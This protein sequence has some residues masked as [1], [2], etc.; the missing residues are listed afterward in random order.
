MP[1]TFTYTPAAGTVLQAGIPEAHGHLHTVRHHRLFRSYHDRRAYGPPGQSGD[2]L[3]PAVRHSAGNA[4]SA[5]QL[6]ATAN[7]PGT[8]SYSPAAGAVLPTGTQQ[9]TV[10]FTP[11]NT[12]DY[13][14]ATAHDSLT[15]TAPP[16]SAPII[17]WNTP[18]PIQYGT[19]LSSVQLNAVA[20]VPG[21]FTYTPAAGTVL[22]AGSQ[23]IT[24]VFTSSDTT[25]HSTAT[26][27]VQELTVTQASPV[28]AWAPLSPIQQGTALSAAQLDATANVP[29]T[30]SYS[31][32]LGAVLPGVRQ[33]SVTFTPSNATDHTSAMAHDPLTVTAASTSTPVITWNTP[34]P[35]QYGTALT[36]VQLNAW[37]TSR[38]TLSTLPAAGAVLQ[39]GSQKLTAIFT[40]SDTAT[41]ST[42]TAAVQL[43]VTQA[44]PVVTWAPLSPIQQGPPSAE[45]SWTPPLMCRV[46]FPTVR[47]RAPFFR[48]AH[49]N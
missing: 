48:Q 21:T 12:T 19:A 43:T 5:A 17:T 7:V 10:T 18:S 27:A 25:A 29:G 9:L 23:K 34:A 6:D 45:C 26:A 49:N 4:L 33:L 20:N 2:H 24:A 30:F 14:S 31:P 3:G 28:I 38:V 40:P 36:S 16:A 13:T 41:Y 44:K 35:I 47:R 11:S 42:A 15:V 37:P 32:A 22:Q 1:G 8:F 39:A 46:P